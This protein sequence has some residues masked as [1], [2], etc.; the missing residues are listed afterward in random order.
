[1]KNKLKT[2]YNELKKWLRSGSNFV[3]ILMLIGLFIIVATTFYISRIIGFYL[4]G[5]LLI[6]I[7]LI[8]YKLTN[9][10]LR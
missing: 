8:F 7:P 1:M 6:T 5:T 4:L 10:K 3:D 2:K 9:K